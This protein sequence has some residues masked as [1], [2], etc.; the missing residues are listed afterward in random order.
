VAWVQVGQ[1]LRVTG[2]YITAGVQL[3]YSFVSILSAREIVDC[4]R[5][6]RNG[7]PVGP[8]VGR[9]RSHSSTFNVQ[10]PLP[11][12]ISSIIYIPNLVRLI[13]VDGRTT[14]VASLSRCNHRLP[15]S[16]MY[17]SESS[18][19]MPPSCAL[20]DSNTMQRSSL[21]TME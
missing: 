16:S 6:T 18:V 2:M 17:M 5:R 21:R 19:D 10:P 7:I 14:Q 3:E 11:P 9:C 1:W 8:H 12:H 15:R 13:V 20:A 4:P